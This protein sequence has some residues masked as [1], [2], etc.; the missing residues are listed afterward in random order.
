[1]GAA[2]LAAVAC[3][4]ATLKLL[5]PSATQTEKV[6]D[7]TFEGGVSDVFADRDCLNAGC[8]SFPPTS[9]TAPGPTGGLYL[10]PRPGTTPAPTA[11]KGRDVWRMLINSGGTIQRQ[12]NGYEVVVGSPGISVLIMKALAKDTA[13]NDVP[14]SGGTLINI[15]DDEYKLLAAWITSGACFDRNTCPVATGTS[16]VPPL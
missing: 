16:G 1:M 8:H 13:G 15:Q 2:S 11:P 4:E 9:P 7:L 14:H 5:E 10:G 6:F 3:G 12:K